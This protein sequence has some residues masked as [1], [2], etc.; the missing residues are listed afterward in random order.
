MQHGVVMPDHWRNFFLEIGWHS[1]AKG[2][3]QVVPNFWFGAGE[4]FGLFM[5]LLGCVLVGNC[6]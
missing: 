1:H 4:C 6:I 5:E 3:G 2:H